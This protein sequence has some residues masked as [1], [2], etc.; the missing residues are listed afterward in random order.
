MGNRRSILLYPFSILYRMVTDLRNL[1]YDTGILKSEEFDLP[2]ICIG[3]ITV[4][5]T[6]KTPHAEYIIDL[7]RKDFKVALLSRGY[8]R[9]SKGFRFV[10]QHSSV[11][12]AGDEPLQVTIK[13]PEII[14]AVDRDRS[15]GIRTILKEHP[16]TEVI[17]LDDGFQHRKVRPGLSILLTDS[18]RLITRDFM[19]PYGNLRENLNNM[20]RADAIVVTKTPETYSGEDMERVAR[21]V[22]GNERQKLFFTSI[23]YADF[24]PLFRSAH[25]EKSGLLQQNRENNGTVLVTGIASPGEVKTYLEKYFKEIIH[26]DFPDHHYFSEKDFE[27]ISKALKELRSEKKVVITTEKD[28]V[29]LREFANI[30]DSLKRSLYFIPVGITILNEKKN[31]FDNMIIEY[32]RKN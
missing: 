26:L 10:S 5:G 19:M 25:T 12:D 31:E 16:E 1:L 11:E 30:D 21:E 28:A 17:I 6:G 32:V 4:G 24:I 7:L 13:F 23:S 15:N 8:K 20:K 29:R 27:K 14:V 9:R 18:S 3:N 22:K 2:V